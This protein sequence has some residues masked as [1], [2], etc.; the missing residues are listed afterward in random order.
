MSKKEEYE[1]RGDVFEPEDDK[2][3]EDIEMDEEEDEEEDSE[4]TEDESEDESEDEEGDDDSD[5]DEDEE[6][7]DDEEDD[8]DG[9]E[10]EQR[11]PK[12]R[13]NQVLRQ[14]DEERERV[15]WLE[16]Q[17]EVL[18]KG[19]TDPE[20]EYEEEESGPPEYDFDAAEG[21]Y[22][23]LILEGEVKEAT[24]LRKEINKAR[25]EL[26]NWQIETARKAAKEDAVT[27]TS[28]S[29]DEARFNT[30]LQGFVEEYAFFND[31]SDAYNERAV[32]MANKLMASY[33]AEGKTKS[34][35]LKA[36]V[37]DIVPLFDKPKSTKTKADERTK[38]A[39]RKAAKAS[40]SQPPK[41]TGKSKGTRDLKAVD[42]TSEKVFNT[43]SAKE[44][45]K[46]RG[47]FV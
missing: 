17:L 7:E 35:A 3:Y 8:D 23:E 33:L 34:Q 47:D 9:E 13:L 36:A 42:I 41:I 31:Q 2:D 19:R 25:D 6:S 43:L 20:E 15:K 16:Q 4:E 26:Y 40:K 24:A 45:A 11:I 22:I 14:R 29:L 38:E 37:E 10:E 32:V 18:I 27:E 44:K 39:R 12:G 5:E 30:M 28:N 21:K 1:D 46:L